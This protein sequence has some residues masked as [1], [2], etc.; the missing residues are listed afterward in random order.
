MSWNPGVDQIGPVAPGGSL[1]AGASVSG[2]TP[3]SL[4][5]TDGSGDLQSGPLTASVGSG[6][7]ISAITRDGSGRVMGM[8]DPFGTLSSVTRDGSGNVTSY[9]YQGVT[10]TVTR[11]GNG[12]VS[13]VS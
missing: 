13:G 4:L 8:V 2:A 11:D 5:V 1:A 10:H 12:R 9:I 3:S 6:S 7:P